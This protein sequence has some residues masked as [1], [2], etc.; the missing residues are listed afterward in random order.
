MSRAAIAVD[1]HLDSN[2]YSRIVTPLTIGEV[3]ARSGFT[4][5]ALRYYE[6][7]G[8]VRPSARSAAGY[9]L[10]GEDALDRLA[11]VAR[12]KQLGCSLDE[13][14]DLLHG[15]GGDECGVVQR[16][17]RELVSTK[18]RATQ[19]QI[20]ELLAF[21]GRL[22]HAANRF[23]APAADGPCRAGCACVAHDDPTGEVAP[24]VLASAPA[25]A[26]QVACTLP[27]EAMA[28][29]MTHWQ[30]VLDSVS[31]RTT[32]PDG[33]LRVQF[34]RD[35]DLVELARLVEAEQRCCPFF[36]FAL[37]VDERGLALEIDAPT[38]ARAAVEAVFGIAR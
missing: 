11:F 28:P 33:R 7:V 22:Q 8:L 36:A 23:H 25:G 17:F 31:A 26:A 13:I 14:T 12:A 19:V 9:R 35:V 27:F 10:Y 24:V 15:F 21:A 18:I 6:R 16:R 37:T 1:L 3:A 20:A 2:P 32:T 29:R 4:A 38:A 5:S 30:A 34:D